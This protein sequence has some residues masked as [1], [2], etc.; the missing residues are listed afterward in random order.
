MRQFPSIIR[1][2][3]KVLVFSLFLIGIV[4]VQAAPSSVNALSDEA[5]RVLGSP[6][7]TTLYSIEPAER[8]KSGDKVL[9]GFKVLGQTNLDSKHAQLAANAFQ[10][11]VT[12]WDDVTYECFEPRHAL[13]ISSR[14][15]TY[16]FLLCY[17]C[18]ELDVYKD[19]KLLDNYGAAGSPKFLN[20]MLTE[21]NVPLARPAR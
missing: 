1:P 17:Q 19:D 11:A 6:H 3:M 20:S 13:R 14:S 16:D 2:R 8:L 5:A 12:N 4:S 18:H 10:K 15:H 7:S 21:A 9:H